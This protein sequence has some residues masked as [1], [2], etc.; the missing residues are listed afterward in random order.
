MAQPA[1][2][3]VALKGTAPG[4]CVILTTDARMLRR[5]FSVLVCT[6]RIKRGGNRCRKSS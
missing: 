1:Y 5:R 4:T 2:P 6:Q 3:S